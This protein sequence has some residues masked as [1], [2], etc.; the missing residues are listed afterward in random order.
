MEPASLS[1]YVFAS[2]CVSFMNKYIKYFLKICF[3]FKKRKRRG[4]FGYRDKG[5]PGRRHVMRDTEIEGMPRN[6]K[7]CCQPPESRKRQGKILPNR[8]QRE[9]GPTDILTLDF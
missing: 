9:H 3:N 2:L 5:D 4:R 1:A 8:I 7:D 6:A